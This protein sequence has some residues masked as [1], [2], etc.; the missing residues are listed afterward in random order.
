MLLSDLLVFKKNSDIT[1]SL[2]AEMEAE[3]AN[4]QIKTKVCTSE[5]HSALQ[6]NKTGTNTMICWI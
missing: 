5:E 1:L 2:M 6:C 3:N 4:V